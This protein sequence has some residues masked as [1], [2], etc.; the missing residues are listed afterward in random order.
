MNARA[1][2]LRC[3]VAAMF[4]ALTVLVGLLPTIPGSAFKFAGFPLL[5]AGLLVGP[6]MGLAVGCLTDI[7][8]FSLRPAGMFFPGFTLTQGL[9]AML[10]GLMSLGRD[11]LTWRPLTAKSLPDQAPT[12]VLEAPEPQR[13]TLASYLR[14]LGIFAVTKVLT[15]VLMVSYFTSKVTLGTPFLYELTQRAIVQAWH[16][17]IYAFLSL[18]V[19]RGLSHTDLYGR[20]LRA[21]R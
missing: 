15:S 8:N 1:V 13:G 4:V 18:A 9:T 21:R 16:V 12:P 5:L 3:S 2:A 19:L 14:L 20:I 7:I 6:R 17:P 10:P 11:P